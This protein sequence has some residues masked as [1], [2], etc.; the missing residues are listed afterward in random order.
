MNDVIVCGYGV[1]GKRIAFALKKHQISFIAIDN[2]KDNDDEIVPLILRTA[3]L[4]P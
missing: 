2:Q 1:I 4:S 3:I